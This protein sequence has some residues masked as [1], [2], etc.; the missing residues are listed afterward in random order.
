MAGSRNSINNLFMDME[1]NIPIYE[2]KVT[3]KY[4]EKIQKAKIAN[5]SWLEIGFYLETKDM[6]RLSLT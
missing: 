4:Y 1:N 2:N 5:D 6:L 3:E